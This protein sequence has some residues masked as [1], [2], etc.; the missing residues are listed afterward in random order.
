LSFECTKDVPNFFR[1]QPVV[2]I[3]KEA[4][5]RCMHAWFSLFISIIFTTCILYSLSLH[6]VIIERLYFKATVVRLHASLLR[7]LSLSIIKLNSRATPLN[8]VFAATHKQPAAKTH[9]EL[10]LLILF[11]A[12][13][14]CV[15][16]S[17]RAC[18]VAEARVSN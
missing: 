9:G 17:E 1:I 16:S 4:F 18:K 7:S 6:Y 2:F 12:A 15:Q 3:I 13:N 8:L 14:R 5:Q 11:W 10:L